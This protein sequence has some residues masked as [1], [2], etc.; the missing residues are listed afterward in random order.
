MKKFYN[1]T[2]WCF[3]FKLFT[4]EASKSDQ[5]APR[6]SSL[7]KFQIVKMQD[8]IDLLLKQKIAANDINRQIIQNIKFRASR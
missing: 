4:I 1:V 8:K 3:V 6:C 7:I 5:T 2:T